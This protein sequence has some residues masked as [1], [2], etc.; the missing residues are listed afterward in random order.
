MARAYS[1]VVVLVALG[2]IFSLLYCLCRL[3][4]QLYHMKY[5]EGPLYNPFYTIEE[6]QNTLLHN[7]K[8][9]K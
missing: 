3:D 4:L 2:F 7:W 8:T 5:L 6:N 9:L 1:T